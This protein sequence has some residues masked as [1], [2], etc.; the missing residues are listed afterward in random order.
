MSCAMIYWGSQFGRFEEVFL[1]F[2]AVVDTRSLHG[3][4]IGV[5]P[6]EARLSLF[7]PSA[8]H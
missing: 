3:K 4:I 8:I 2:G 5:S 6:A 1:H 7:A